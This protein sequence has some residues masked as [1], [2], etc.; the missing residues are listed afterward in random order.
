[1]PD[2]R[3]PHPEQ[4]GHNRRGFEYQD[5]THR[6]RNHNGLDAHEIQIE[7]WFPV[8]EK[9]FETLAKIRVQFVEAGAL[10]VRAR[11]TG[12]IPDEQT[13]LRVTLNYS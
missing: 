13:C 11:E 1:M 12:H 2:L 8:F 7:S 3:K 10:R 6:S 4:D 5:V 9:H